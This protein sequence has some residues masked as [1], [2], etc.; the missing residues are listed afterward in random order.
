[1]NLL[2]LQSIDSLIESAIKDKYSGYEI[3]R[4]ASGFGISKES[5][6][7]VRQ[8]SYDIMLKDGSRFVADGNYNVSTGSVTIKERQY[9][10]Y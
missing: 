1:V 2:D 5:P 10:E 6:N 7:G 9:V 8:I 3:N 4:Y